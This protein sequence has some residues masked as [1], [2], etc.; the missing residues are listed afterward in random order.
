MK[1]LLIYGVI[2]YLCI[3]ILVFFFA[4]YIIF[5]PPPVSYHDSNNIIK[6]K[7]QD[8]AIISAVHLHNPQAKYTI[9]YSHGN[10][11]DIGEMFSL[12]K[13]LENHGYSVFAYDY[14]G[15]GT[16]TG[17]P[18]EK[19]SYY[20]IHAAYDYLTQTLKIPP[21]QIIAYG[22]SVGAA[23]SLDLAIH[24][25][26]GGIIMESPFVTAFRTV[27]VIPLLPFDK[28][29]NLSKISRISCPILFIHG[30]KD[31]TIAIWHSKKL[32]SMAKSPKYYLWVPSAGHNDFY[33]DNAGY[34]QA[35]D[36]LIN[37]IEKN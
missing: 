1:R 23:V 33:L 12:F 9:L 7:T 22:K 35:I 13:V 8:G 32:Y 11:T 21:K 30:E 2:A 24:K 10:A 26:L 18:S 29:N 31:K 36:Q 34:W 37:A 25:P 20:D 6:L 27:T 16:S 4:D 28:F 5:Q 14:H 17:K 15:Y 19:N 3:A